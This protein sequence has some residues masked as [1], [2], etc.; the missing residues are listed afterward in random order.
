MTRW[1]INRNNRD[2]ILIRTVAPTATPISV[3]EAKANLR[4]ED[5]DEDGLITSLIDRAVAVVDAEGQ[6]GKAMVTQTWSQAFHAP[7]GRVFTKIPAATLVSASYYDTSN[8][9]Q[10]LTIGDYNLLIHPDW[11]FI[12]PDEGVSWPTTYSRP[13]A[14]TFIFTAGYGAATAVPDNI[15][16][17]LILLV[18]HWYENRQPVNIGSISTLPFGFDDLIGQSKVGFYG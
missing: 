3:L 9:S 5:N 4:I 1:S 14:I 12:C 7:G 18:S 11:S 15:K 8:N 16:Q 6:L 13:D 10:S 17:A 2:H